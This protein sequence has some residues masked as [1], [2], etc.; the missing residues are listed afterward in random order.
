MYTKLSDSYPDKQTHYTVLITDGDA[1]T[2]C[3]VLTA[4]VRDVTYN[5]RKTGI[6]HHSCFPL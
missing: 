6:F 2:A 4:G 5:R 3:V 1:D